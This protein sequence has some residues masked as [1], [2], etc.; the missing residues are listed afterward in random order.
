MLQDFRGPEA[1]IHTRERF[2]EALRDLFQLRGR[3][4]ELS[5][6]SPT[7]Q[8]SCIGSEATLT[9]DFCLAGASV[10]AQVP[11]WLSSK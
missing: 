6:V 11:H 7:A 2:Q 10:A 8:L 1:V 3:F 4:C 9:S 5:N